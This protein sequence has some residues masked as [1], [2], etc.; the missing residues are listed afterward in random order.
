MV[1]KS[2][3]VTNCHQKWIMVVVLS[4]NGEEKGFDSIPLAYFGLH[5]HHIRN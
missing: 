2:Q 1:Y 3:I 5:L 4:K